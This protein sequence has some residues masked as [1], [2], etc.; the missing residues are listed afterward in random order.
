M[1]DVRFPTPPDQ[2]DKDYFD[3]LIRNIRQT[4][5]GLMTPGT[6]TTGLLVFTVDP[7][8]CPTNPSG[9]RPGTVYCD[10]GTLKMVLPNVGYA[11]SIELASSLGTVRATG[12]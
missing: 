2:Y 4:F 9:L 3:Q 6:V 1:A 5:I 8:G 11:P 7:R 12:I 10:N